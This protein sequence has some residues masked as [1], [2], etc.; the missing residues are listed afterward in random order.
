[1]HMTEIQETDSCE[2]GFSNLEPSSREDFLLSKIVPTLARSINM[3]SVARTM[4]M[5]GPSVVL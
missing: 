3:L 5:I 2:K 4:G 1:M